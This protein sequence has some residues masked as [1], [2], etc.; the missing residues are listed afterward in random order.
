MSVSSRACPTP[1]LSVLPCAGARSCCRPPGGAVHPGRRPKSAAHLA[2]QVVRA[3]PSW[4]QSSG[5]RVAGF[6]RPRAAEVGEH[7][8]EQISPRALAL[9]H[10]ITLDGGQSAPRA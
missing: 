7:V 2:S 5:A 6:C 9:R 1:L 3:M 4:R 10:E 8:N